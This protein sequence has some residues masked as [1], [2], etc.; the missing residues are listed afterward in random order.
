MSG[1][2]TATAER[3]RGRRRDLADRARRA[4]ADAQHR[5]TGL[6]ADFSEQVN[7]RFNDDV[8]NAIEGAARDEIRLI[9]RALA[10]I[11][12]GEYG[13]CTSCGAPVAEERLAAVP[14]AESC[15]DCAEFEARHRPG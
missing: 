8:L 11:A 14:Y 9:D 6:S 15:A 2:F 5:E 3:L 12:R 10:R 13:N 1:A 4:H 7:E